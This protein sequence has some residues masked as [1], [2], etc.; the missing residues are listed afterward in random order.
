MV[1]P[2]YEVGDSE[3]LCYRI[4]HTSN[5]GVVGLFGSGVCADGDDRKPVVK[6]VAVLGIAC[7]PVALAGIAAASPCPRWFWPRSD[8]AIDVVAGRAASP[9]PFSNLSCRGQA[10]HDGHFH[11]HQDA[12]D[13]DGLCWV[14][15]EVECLLAVVGHLYVITVLDQL[16]L[17]HS[18]IE[19][20][21]CS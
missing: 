2:R 19:S 14:C 16:L 21:V 9:F 11:V 3:R 20:V 1:N 10:I 17:E 8:A 18:L 7:T 13:L 4:I 6:C 12:V 5:D 15:K